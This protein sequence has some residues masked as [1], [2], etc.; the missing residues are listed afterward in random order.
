[1]I[2]A[3]HGTNGDGQGMLEESGARAL[4]DA[5]GVVVVAPTARWFGSEGSDYDHPQGN[6]T[7][8]ETRSSDVHRNADLVL[9]RAILTE[10]ERSLRVDTDR[11]YALGHSNGGFMALLVAVA[12]RDRIAAFAENSAGMVTCASRP[13]CTFQGSARS[14]AEL[15]RE[16]GWCACDTAS[17]PVAIP[18]TGHRVPGYLSH[19]VQDPMV[20][21]YYTCMLAARLAAA[22]VPVQ[23]YLW[24]GG[25]HLG[26]SFARRAWSFFSLHRLRS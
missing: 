9:V 13:E 20:S 11:V 10:S 6:G 17:H 15:S 24:E 18:D 1:L 4:A 3:F 5:E 16:A 23:T 25:H 12:L 7:Y 21:V 26:A 14:C 22:G 19:G 8:W 2:V